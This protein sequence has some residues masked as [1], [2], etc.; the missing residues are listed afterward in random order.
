M[1]NCV[2]QLIFELIWS[3]FKQQFD[4]LVKDAHLL[5]FTFVLNKKFDA[6]FTPALSTNATINA[7]QQI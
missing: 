4:I 3:D 5:S 2:L 7:L 6:T 1:V